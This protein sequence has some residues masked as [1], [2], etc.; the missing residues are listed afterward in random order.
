M[1]II[2]FF[3]ISTFA[4]GL[5]ARGV[6]KEWLIRV[7]EYDVNESNEQESTFNWHDFIK[8]LKKVI[9]FIKKIISIHNL[10]N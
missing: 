1:K 5:A 8:N 10:Y 9:K 3:L 6:L 4:T 2:Y 7:S